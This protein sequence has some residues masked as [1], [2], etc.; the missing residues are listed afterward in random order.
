MVNIRDRVE[1]SLKTVMD[2]HMGVN[3]ADM[4]MLRRIDVAAEGDV[5]VGLVFPC[6]GCPAYELIKAD[7]CKSAAAVEGVNSVKVKVDWNEDWQK[8]DM[9]E[10]ARQRAAVHGYVI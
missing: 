6:I 4:G 9:A 10:S 1:E 3:L 2:P 7:V 5:E 8:T